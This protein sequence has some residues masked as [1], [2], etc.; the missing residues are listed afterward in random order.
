MLNID[1]LEMIEK[2]QMNKSIFIHGGKVRRKGYLWDGQYIP[3]KERYGENAELR[4]CI[5]NAA[6][7]VRSCL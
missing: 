1:F 2:T 7:K 6:V 5:G 4:T 3:M